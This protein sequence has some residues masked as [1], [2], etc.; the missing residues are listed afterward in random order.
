MFLMHLRNPAQY[1][2]MQSK[3]LTSSDLLKLPIGLLTRL[4]TFSIS[5]A[6]F[7]SSLAFWCTHSTMHTQTFADF[8]LFNSYQNPN[9]NILLRMHS[10]IE[11]VEKKTHAM[12]VVAAATAAVVAVFNLFLVTRFGH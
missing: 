6:V 12:F 11:P 7:Y 3:S 4:F 5:L 8:F 9:T 1:H 2:E 10:S